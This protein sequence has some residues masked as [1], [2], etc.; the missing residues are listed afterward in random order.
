MTNWATIC[1]NYKTQ[2]RKIAESQITNDRELVIERVFDA[3]LDLVYAAWTT[4]NQIAKWYGPEGF[5]TTVTEFDFRPGG[6]WRYVMHGPDGNEYPVVGT[7]KEISSD[8]I[9]TIDEFTEPGQAEGPAGTIL[10]TVTFEDIGGKTKLTLTH[11]HQSVENARRFEEM[12]AMHGWA[13]SFS[14]LNEVLA[15]A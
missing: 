15:A 13:S 10:T 9:V 12:G 6:A 1:R 14:R 11:L 7:F 2:R 8:R 4:P 5:E 3:P